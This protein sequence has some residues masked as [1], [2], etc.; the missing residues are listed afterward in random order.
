[1]EKELWKAVRQGNVDLVKDLLDKGAD[2]EA[3]D[4][5]NV[6]LSNYYY[7]YSNSY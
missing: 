2:L 4:P 5:S 3:K 1:M 6:S 7:Y